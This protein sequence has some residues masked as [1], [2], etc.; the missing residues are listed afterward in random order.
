MGQ[1]NPYSR[2]VA[3][4]GFYGSL[5]CEPVLRCRPA[6]AWALH[7]F[8]NWGQIHAL[9]RRARQPRSWPVVPVYCVRLCSRCMLY[10]LK[11]DKPII[12]SKNKSSFTKQVN[13]S[14]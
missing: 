12:R 2:S 4:P 9:Y 5:G 14:C 8:L 7:P 3:D 11:W 6:V 1:I 10:M 13:V